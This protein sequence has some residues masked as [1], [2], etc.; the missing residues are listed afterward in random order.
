MFEKSDFEI[1]NKKFLVQIL[2][3]AAIS[4]VFQL[5]IDPFIYDPYVRQ[6]MA[7]GF[8]D[9]GD[10]IVITS[11]SMW[12][13]SFSIAFFYYPENEI[14]NSYLLCSFVPL[15]GIVAGEFICLMF[16]DFLHLPPVIIIAI[17]IFWKGRETLDMRTIAISSIIL[18]FWLLTV[19]LLG[20]NYATLQTWMIVVAMG[21]WPVLNLILGYIL[22]KVLK[23]E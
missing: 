21:L 2:I 19:H 10:A 7:G 11:M 22:I 15:I 4:V 13:F 18:S 6:A 20:F 8:I 16:Y 17:F 23:N 14:I 9:P 1:D 5:F 12:F 3:A